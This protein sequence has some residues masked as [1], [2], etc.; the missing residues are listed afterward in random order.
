[1]KAGLKAATL[2]E[3]I[4]AMVIIVVCFGIAMMIYVNVLDSDKQRIKLDSSLILEKTAIQMKHDRRYLDEQV[5]AGDF[6]IQSSFSNYKQGRGLM[7][8][9]LKLFDLS[10]KLIAERKELILTK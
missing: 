4:I 3:S 10:G 6:V 8:F 9:S 7:E 5:L 1:M 2:I